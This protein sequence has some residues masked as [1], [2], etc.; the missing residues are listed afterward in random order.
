MFV[1]FGNA[2]ALSKL[3]FYGEKPSA[4]LLE[5]GAGWES[6]QKEGEKKS[7]NCMLLHARKG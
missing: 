3:K 6:G 4:C 5:L 7:L 1:Y 2:K